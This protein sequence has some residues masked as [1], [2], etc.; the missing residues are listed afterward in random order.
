MVG[1]SIL[2]Q[3]I[4]ELG[5]K[6][7]PV[8]VSRNVGLMAV[9]VIGSRLAKAGTGLGEAQSHCTGCGDENCEVF[10]S[11]SV[12]VEVRLGYETGHAPG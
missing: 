10:P 4:L 3:R 8:A 6:S 5:M 9:I 11:E 7:T 1:K 2:F 12:V